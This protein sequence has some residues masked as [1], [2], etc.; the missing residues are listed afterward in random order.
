[1][2]EEQLKKCGVEYFDFYLL[3]NVNE[4]SMYYYGNRD[5]GCVEYFLAQ[6]AAGRIRHLGFSCHAA[7]DCLEQFLALY[8]E[9]MEFCQI[10]LNF[11]D[12]TL[13]NA[14]KKCEILR[15]AG[16]PVWVMEPLRGGRLASL[17]D[18][19]EAKM[20]AL[21]PDESIPAWAFRWLTTVPK[22]P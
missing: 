20:H 21:R 1:V 18:E 22:R 6:K 7:V 15:D 12:W 5:S 2:F 13:Q 14:K 11:V 16:L 8:G 19:T 17:D 9:Q 10:Q 3:H 4:N